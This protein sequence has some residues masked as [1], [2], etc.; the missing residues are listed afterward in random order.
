MKKKPK[1]AFDWD[2]FWQWVVDAI[3]AWLKHHKPKDPVHKLEV[4]VGKEVRKMA[5]KTVGVPFPCRVVGKGT[6]GQDVDL[7]ALGA[8]YMW[9]ASD[10]SLS[11]DDSSLATPQCTGGAPLT[12]A[13][14]SVHVAYTIGGTLFSHD[15]TS[16]PFDVA[17]VVVEDPVVAL[18]VTT[19]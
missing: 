12:G 8:T 10:P 3:R 14:V 2:A 13:T 7:D 17:A 4:F 18:V 11:F 6:A 19:G 9:S 1:P 15:G 16:D 5:T